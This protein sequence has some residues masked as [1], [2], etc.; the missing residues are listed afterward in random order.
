MTTLKQRLKQMPALRHAP[1]C[2]RAE[3]SVRPANR[4]TPLM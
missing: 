1:G 2:A 3:D 4:E